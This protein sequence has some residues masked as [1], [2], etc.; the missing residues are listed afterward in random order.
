[1]N[2]HQTDLLT[3]C[4]QIVNGFL[5]CFCNRTHSDDNCLC[6]FSTIIIE[7]LVI[8]SN[9]LV[10]FVH[11][12]F[13]Y[14]RQTVIERVSSFFSLEENI[15]VLSCTTSYRMLRVQCVVTELRYSVPVKHLSEIFII[16]YFNFL[17]LVRSAESIKEVKERN[18]SLNC[19]QV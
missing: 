11:I 14:L 8:S 4:C 15:G 16:P 13:N 2:F 10:D 17:D 6:I 19:G 7:E 1:M 3:F 18:T 9:A 5:S 12:A